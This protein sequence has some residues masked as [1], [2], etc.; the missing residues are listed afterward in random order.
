MAD[1]ICVLLV[2]DDIGH[3]EL[4]SR[5]FEAKADRVDLF[6]VQNLEQAQNYILEGEPD[7]IIMDLL[8]PD[9]T[10]LEFLSGNKSGFSFPVIL[11][12]SHGDEQIAVEAMKA[13]ALD[14]VVKSA[15]T[16][17]DMPRIAERA[18]REWRHIAERQQFEKALQESEQRFRSVIEQ[19]TDGIVLTDE[20]GLIIEWNQGAERVTGL[21]RQDV[22]ERPFGDVQQQLVKP[23]GK[24]V[25]VEFEQF[26]QEWAEFYVTG[27]APWLNKV[28]DVRYYH[29]D[30]RLNTVEMLSFPIKTE[31]GYMAGSILRDV[32]ASRQAEE[33]LHQQERLAA[34]GQLAAGIAHDFNNIMAVIVLYAQVSLQTPGLPTRV[35][36]RLDTMVKQAKRAAELID[37]ILDFSRRTVLE[38][39]PLNLVS[40]LKEN[41]RL[42]RRTLPEN[43]IVELSYDEPHCAIHGDLTRIQHTIMNLALNARDAMPHGGLLHIQITHHHFSPN[44]PVPVAQM[45]AG[46]YISLM[47]TDSGTGIA[48]EIKPH[49]FEPFF[50]TKGPGKG[51]GLG[52]AQ[53]Y[54]IV[55]QHEGHIDVQ[56]K[57]EEGTTFALYF[58]DLSEQPEDVGDDTFDLH[59]GQGQ[60][61]LLVEDDQLVREVMSDS[62]TLINYKVIE[63]ANG[64]Q[65][66]TLLDQDRIQPALIIS[67]V[68]MPEMGG[69]ELFYALQKRQITLPMLLVSGHPIDQQ[70]VSLKSLGHVESMAKPPDLAQL[71]QL[72]Y[73]M[74]QAS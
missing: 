58:P 51:T 22:W 63:A 33:Q 42:L 8:L 20:Q 40:L 57:L 55:K 66:L 65:A 23:R 15:D 49:L 64:Y 68:V 38:R 13:G 17:L 70:I 28:V 56:T 37:Q 19:S 16:L 43:I 39:R 36:E 29:V 14:Y 53:V 21:K 52:L 5:A 59:I 67:D 10:G 61:I 18:L 6:V 60:L 35:Q 27:Q 41:V 31:K 26:K 2:E 48:E 62:L 4:I 46:D 7:L 74:L 24:D 73:D 44:Q 3:T 12:T 47:I 54:G 11:M 30:G 71:A 1:K 50:T 72:V 25:L 34:V 69:I 32:T 9:G 45:E